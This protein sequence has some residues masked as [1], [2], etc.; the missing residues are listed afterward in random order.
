M[1]C[2]PSAPSHAVFGFGSGSALLYD[3]EAARPLL[4]MEQ[5]C[6]GERGGRGGAVLCH[7]NGGALRHI[8]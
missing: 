5:R 4:A 2:C 8:P 6:G 3:M 7:S 1:S